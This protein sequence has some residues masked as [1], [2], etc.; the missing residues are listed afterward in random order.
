MDT[1]VRILLTG[2]V[3]LL[4]AQIIPSVRVK[5]F[6]S[7]VGVAAVYAFLNFLLKELLMIVSM[8]MIVLSFGLFLLVLNG[9]LLWLTDKILTSF[10]IK[11]KT[12]LVLATLGM[13]FGSVVVDGVVARIF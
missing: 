4:I 10:E 13:T 3:V 12:G 11:T 5:N 8:P 7:A 2:G 1:V 9:F 6:M